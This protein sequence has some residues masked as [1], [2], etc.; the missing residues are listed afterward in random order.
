MAEENYKHDKEYSSSLLDGLNNL[1]KQNQ[2]F[3]ITIKVG[4]RDFPAH[5]AVLAAVS[6]YFAAMF[7]SGF[8]ESSQSK[9]EIDG[10]PDAFDMLLEFA[11]TGRI[12]IS[13]VKTNIFD[14]FEM[15]LYMDFKEFSWSCSTVLEELF[16][17][18]PECVTIEEAC[19]VLF[20]ARDHDSDYNN[21]YDL[22]CYSQDILMGSLEVLKDTEVF[23]ANAT[24]KFLDEFLNDEDL[25]TEMEEK[26]VSVPMK[27]EW[28]LWYS[29]ARG[30][31]F[32]GGSHFSWFFPG[33][34]FAFSW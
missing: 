20:L 21:L 8:R 23:L 16:R 25:A 28:M 12:N 26:Q 22:V 13:K 33:M 2:L 18:D 31:F 3:D 6:S 7:T 15:S 27:K 32:K 29:C 30:I 24:V 19:K 5:K 10:N 4:G 1:R 34:K 14:V 11:Y 17:S 9:I